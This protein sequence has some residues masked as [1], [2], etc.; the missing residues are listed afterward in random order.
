MSSALLQN[1]E[2]YRAGQELNVHVC[3][4]KTK[5]GLARSVT[6]AIRYHLHKRDLIL[7][8]K[9]ERQGWAVL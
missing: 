6:A 4:T 8:V 5:T 9:T 7:T 2:R 1:R 3:Q